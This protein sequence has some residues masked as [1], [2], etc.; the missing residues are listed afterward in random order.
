MAPAM[1]IVVNAEAPRN[2]LQVF[3][4]PIA[5]IPSHFRDQF[6]RVRHIVMVSLAVP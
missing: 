3:N 4:P 5:R 1:L 6:G 2:H